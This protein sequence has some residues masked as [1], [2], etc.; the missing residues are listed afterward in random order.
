M[1]N[2]LTS[3]NFLIIPKFIT[4]QNAEE[5]AQYLK[6][7]RHTGTYGG[8]FQTPKSN[9]FAGNIRTLELLTQKT[10]EVS[11]ILKEFVLPTYSYARIYHKGAELAPH[12]DRAACEISLTVHLDS[13]KQ[14]EFWIDNPNGK[15]K[16]INLNPGDAVMYLGC[17]ALHGRHNQYEGEEYTQVFLHYVRSRGPNAW[18]YF[19]K[20]EK[21]S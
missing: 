7:L 8:D 16:Y 9:A 14:W 17:L 6:E 11:D 13:D 1:N 19:D 4:P 18:A 5:L 20:T 10:P 3:N 15:R 21:P 2:E 12:K